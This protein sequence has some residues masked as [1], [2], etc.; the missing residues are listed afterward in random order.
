MESEKEKFVEADASGQLEQMRIAYNKPV[1]LELGNR[2]YKFRPITNKCLDL[3]SEYYTKQEEVSQEDGTAGL[4]VKLKPNI[5]LQCK[6]FSIAIL[7]DPRFLMGWIKVNLFHRFH[8]RIL[9]YRH[10]VD[11]MLQATS[12]IIEKLSLTSFFFLTVSTK[13]M[14]SLKKKKTKEEVELL[15]A[16]QES[17]KKQDS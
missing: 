5:K 10:N 14:N 11:E 12:H 17:E 6:A 4:I 3:I 15:R 8:W 2:K 13:G 9:M 7:N 16:E 1:Y